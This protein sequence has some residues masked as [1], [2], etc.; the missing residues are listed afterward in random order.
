MP[1][2]A[3]VYLVHGPQWF[4]P[5]ALARTV[6]CDGVP[7]GIKFKVMI[8]APGSTAVRQG[9]RSILN[10]GCGLKKNADAINLDLRSEVNPD[11]VHDLNRTPWPFDDSQFSRV[12]AYDVL[13][14][15]DDVIAVMDEIHRISANQG[16]V[17]I[18][19][20][21]FSCV[22]A[23][24][25]PTHRHFFG[26]SSF[27]YITGEREP[28]FYTAKRFRRLVSRIVFFPVGMNR[29]IARFA[30]RY[31]EAYEKRWAWIFPAWFLYF[32]LEVIK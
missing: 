28:S 14:H 18:T 1:S 8:A 9:T 20:P 10:L 25:D 2:S 26:W 27:H 3:C 22:N 11:V 19:V 32:E 24:I 15:C 16:T 12:L 5:Q 29:L 23:F 30:N 4:R 21:H 31:P 7:V 17:E 13:E 6:R